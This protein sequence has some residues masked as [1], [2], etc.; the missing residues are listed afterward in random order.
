MKITEHHRR[1]K[2]RGGKRVKGNISRVTRAQHE[3]WHT[4]FDN[5]KVSRMC[6][7]FRFFYDLFGEDS[8]KNARDQMPHD[9]RINNWIRGT[10][11][12]HVESRLRKWHA[13]MTLFGGKSLEKIIREI[14]EVWIDPTFRLEARTEI[15]YKKISD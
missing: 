8:Q 9:Q 12:R 15:F 6:H 5:Y 4:L 11:K 3:A 7:E 1:P 2:S 10:N 14:N 13:W